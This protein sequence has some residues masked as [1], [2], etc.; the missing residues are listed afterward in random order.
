MTCYKPVQIELQNLKLDCSSCSD[1]RE[2]ESMKLVK[3]INQSVVSERRESVT[4]THWRSFAKPRIAAELHYQRQ[5][6]YV[7]YKGNIKNI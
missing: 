1:C 4:G 3:Q 5:V 7:P 6:K 2:G